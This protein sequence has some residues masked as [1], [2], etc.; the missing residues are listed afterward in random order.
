MSF[1][2]PGTWAGDLLRLTA[3]VEGSPRTI[4]GRL[5]MAGEPGAR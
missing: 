1:A 4:A 5:Q 2:G 3:I